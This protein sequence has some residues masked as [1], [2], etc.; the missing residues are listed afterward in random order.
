MVLHRTSRRILRP[1]LSGSLT[2]GACGDGDARPFEDGLLGIRLARHTILLS[3]Y[4]LFYL[5]IVRC[6]RVSRLLLRCHQI[7]RTIPCH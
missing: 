7:Q 6:F 3:L 2:L 5:L 4:L 1:S